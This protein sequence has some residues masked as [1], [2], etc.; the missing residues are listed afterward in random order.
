MEWQDHFATDLLANPDV[1]TSRTLNVVWDGSSRYRPGGVADVSSTNFG[2][3]HLWHLNS[4]SQLRDNALAA[5]HARNEGAP[6][7]FLSDATAPL[8]G[9][10]A[11]FSE[12]SRVGAQQIALQPTTALLQGFS[13]GGWIRPSAP[14]VKMILEQA[15]NAIESR[16]FELAV[17]CSL[18]GSDGNWRSVRSAPNSVP[19]KEWS[20]FVCTYGTNK[21][22]TLYLNGV[23]VA[24]ETVDIPGNELFHYGE[25]GI[26]NRSI[27]GGAEASNGFDGDIT[28]LAFWGREITPEEARELAVGTTRLAPVEAYVTSDRITAPGGRRFT[29]A[30]I[31]TIGEIGAQ[32]LFVSLGGDRWY[33]VR[34]GQTLRDIFP[35]QEEFTGLRLKT[36]FVT[37]NSSLDGWRVRFTALAPN[38]PVVPVNMG[39][40]VNGF[41]YFSNGITF[42]DL[43]EYSGYFGLDRYLVVALLPYDLPKGQYTF[44]QPNSGCSAWVSA[45]GYRS[46]TIPEGPGETLLDYYPEG[47]QRHMWAVSMSCPNQQLSDIV[48][49]K[50]LIPGYHNTADRPQFHPTYLNA[51]KR[52]RVL[53]YL[54]TLATNNSAAERWEDRPLPTDLVYD[55]AKGAPIELTIELAALT[56]VPPWFTVPHKVDANY[57][58]QLAELIKRTLPAHLPVY[59]EYSN[60][61]WNWGFQQD[62]WLAE[63]VANP[64]S[65]SMAQAVA[66]KTAWLGGI[67]NEVLG[68]DRVKLV[69]GGFFDYWNREVLEAFSNPKVNPNNV[70]PDALA[71]APYLGHS[72]GG[73]ASDPNTK[74]ADVTDMLW[75]ELPHLR[76]RLRGHKAL[77]DEFGVEIIGYESGQHLIAPDNDRYAHEK[78]LRVNQEPQMEAFY[79]HYFKIW[80]EELDTLVGHYS[81]VGANSKW[82][83]W[84]L[85][86]HFTQD[87]GERPKWNAVRSMADAFQAGQTGMVPVCG[88]GKR[89]GGEQCDG[90]EFVDGVRECAAFLPS[91]YSA[92]TLRCAADCTWNLEG[93]TVRRCEQVVRT[94]PDNNDWRRVA[95]VG[96][97]LKYVAVAPL[98]ISCS[99][100]SVKFELFYTPTSGA[101]ERVDT[102]TVPF[103]DPYLVATW[104]TLKAP[105]SPPAAGTKMKYTLQA[106]V[107][108]ETGRALGAAVRDD[109]PWEVYP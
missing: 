103:E 79:K 41:N 17:N 95:T 69:V 96:D 30:T 76:A 71:V 22:L 81:F 51:L 60:E 32:Q 90:D 3:K 48:R 59:V 86:T 11:R 43:L 109:W 38:V 78:L 25:L 40:N 102:V 52:F 106:T 75:A 66:Q 29:N 36:S 56:N 15:W 61:L 62:D 23:K 8:P 91:G 10:F 7:Q 21:I 37:G 94:F 1:D 97:R 33:A 54:D 68:A 55:P 108:D 63:N 98:G 67:F 88:N 9:G 45:E 39:V 84:P 27:N 28:E 65:L 50:L 72:L 58:R 13:Y 77:G 47:N 53:R 4:E 24:Q 74:V 46:W 42:T 73:P 93:C 83:Y 18:R 16:F 104:Q 99:G 107:V 89:E 87:P 80:R 100:N 12:L 5:N 35:A 34:S 64:Q 57:V 101:E 6:L 14:A 31:E 105:A 82:G 2:L 20:H 70:R 49:P 26:G 85:L 92:G 44:V 19:A